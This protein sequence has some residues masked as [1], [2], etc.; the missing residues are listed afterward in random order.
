M[1]NI[2]HMNQK[3]KSFRV[4]KNW[5]PDERTREIYNG[6]PNKKEISKKI[7]VAHSS[8]HIMIENHYKFYIVKNV[9]FFS[10]LI[11]S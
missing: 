6:N 7:K 3:K 1:R 9:E 4:G 8:A 10:F 2:K 5:N 11:S